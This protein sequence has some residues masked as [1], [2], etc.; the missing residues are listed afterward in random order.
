M[1]AHVVVLTA[2]DGVDR[3]ADVMAPVV[4]TAMPLLLRC[5]RELRT[6]ERTAV[7][8]FGRLEICAVFLQERNLLKAA[9]VSDFHLPD[10]ARDGC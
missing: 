5:H 3:E 4:V 8:A 7:V 2:E 6:G 10:K 9:T 1:V